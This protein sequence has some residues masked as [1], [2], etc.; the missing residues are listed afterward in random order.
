MK[1]EFNI[2]AFY[3]TLLEAFEDLEHELVEKEK[4]NKA[5]EIK[6]AID[7]LKFEWELESILNER[8]VIY[9]NSLSKEHHRRLRN[10]RP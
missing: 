1:Q 8:N 10:K 2:D 7:E 5:A 9:T 3:S 6:R 4:Y